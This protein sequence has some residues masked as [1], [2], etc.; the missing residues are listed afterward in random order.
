SPGFKF[1]LKKHPA[2]D[3]TGKGYV[4]SSIEHAATEASYEVGADRGQ[5]Y[6]NTFTC[7][8][9]AVPFHPARTT[10][11]PVVQGPQT[12]VVVGPKGE[13]IYTDK[14][15]RVK[16]QFHW[17]RYGHRDENSSCWM[18]VAQSWAGK[19]WGTMFI[20]RIGMEVIV[21]FLE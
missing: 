8:P 12:A 18:R 17:D 19:K 14:Y 21:N 10:P 11:K 15:G 16:V 4:I 3:E 6:R 20:P 2:K 7:I 1:T 5:A 9:E 13:E